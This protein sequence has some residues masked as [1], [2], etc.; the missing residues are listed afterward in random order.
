MAHRV[1]HL[2]AMQET[3]VRSMGQEDPLEKEMAT[4]FSILACRIPLTEEPGELHS[5][6]SQRAG[7]AFTFTFTF[8]FVFQDGF[9]SYSNLSKMPEN[10]K[11]DVMQ[12]FVVELQVHGHLPHMHHEFIHLDQKRYKFSKPSAI[13]T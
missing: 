3:W 12:T 5:M 6:G 9:L 2:S 11:S 4:H 1:K 7:H 13:S 10:K 8:T